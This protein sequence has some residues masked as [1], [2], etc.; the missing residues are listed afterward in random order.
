MKTLFTI[1]ALVFATNA[2]SDPGL[3]LP[4]EVKNLANSGRPGALQ[5]IQLGT[6]L[7]DKKVQVLKA[8]YSFAV[9]GGSSVANLVLKDES[10]KEATLPAKAVIKN[11]LIDVLTAPIGAAS[12][13]IGT[14]SSAVNLKAALTA[15]SLTGVVA[16]IPVSAATAV[17]LSTQATVKTRITNANLTAGKFNV[18]IE[19]FVSE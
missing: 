1:L 13:S 7:V 6:Q 5:K 8:Q 18:F 12:V 9:L 10:G 15:T 17:K 19:Y 11:V 3:P 4:A 2:M 14:D 16:G